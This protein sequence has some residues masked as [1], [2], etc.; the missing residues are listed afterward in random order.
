MHTAHLLGG[1]L[2]LALACGVPSGSVV[3]ATAT[4]TFLVTANVNVNCTIQA[5]NLNFGDY[6]NATL[7][8]QSTITLI[9]TNSAEWNIGLNQ[10]TFAGAT[11]TTRK[12]TGPGSFS[13]AYSLFSDPARTINWGN[14][15]GTDTVSGVGTGT[16]E[17]IPVY[18][19]IPAGQTTAG[20][21]GY[22]DTITA[23]V[24]F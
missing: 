3:P 8:G 7:N 4:A 22:V 2:L 1:G 6:I 19:Q 17:V 5:A 14:T 15:V 9:C 11:V 12:M 18:G 20:S 10:G 21:G 13:L 23:T 24:T 16:T